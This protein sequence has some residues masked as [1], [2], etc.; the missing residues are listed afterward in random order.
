MKKKL[1]LVLNLLL[2]LIIGSCNLSS[3][4]CNLSSNNKVSERKIHN[5]STWNRVKFIGTTLFLSKVGNGKT[6][7]KMLINNSLINYNKSISSLLNKTTKEPF[8]PS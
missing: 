1:T 4:S 2:F 6:L 8:S 7:N 5:Q 3:N